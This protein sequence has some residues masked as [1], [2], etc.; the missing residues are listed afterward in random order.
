MHFILY[1]CK[2]CKQQQHEA[3]THFKDAGVQVK[4][5]LTCIMYNY[6]SLTLKAKPQTLIN[7]TDKHAF[8]SLYL[9]FY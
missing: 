9:T 7:V 3:T 1:K 8:V 4:I 6:S 2:W 5:A